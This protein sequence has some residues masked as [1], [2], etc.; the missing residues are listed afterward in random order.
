MEVPSTS[1]CQW[2]LID[3]SHQRLHNMAANI[4]NLA[5]QGH[6]RDESTILALQNELI[7][8]AL[9]NEL[10]EASAIQHALENEYE[11][12]LIEAHQLA[13]QEVEKLREQIAQQ[14]M[15]QRK[16]QCGLADA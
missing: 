3:D 11:D 6:T 10:I 4:C 7:I 15:A 1:A 12:A 8:L 9:R 16:A 2:T 14:Q 5:M 13:R